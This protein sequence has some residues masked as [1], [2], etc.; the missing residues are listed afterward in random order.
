[1]LLYGTL[2][3]LFQSHCLLMLFQGKSWIWSPEKQKYYKGDFRNCHKKSCLLT[4]VSNLFHIFVT[5]EAGDCR[6]PITHYRR[7]PL[8]Q[9]A[10]LWRKSLWGVN[11]KCTMNMSLTSTTS[12]RKMTANS[13]F[14]RN[15]PLKD[16]PDSPEKESTLKTGSEKPQRIFKNPS[17]IIVNKEGKNHTYLSV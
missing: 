14:W 11:R 13:K 10:V 3:F 1:M 16:W 12:I 9:G 15:I 6:S 8:R 7:Q 2:C 17:L 5:E 4:D